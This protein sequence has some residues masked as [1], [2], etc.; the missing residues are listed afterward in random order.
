MAG[1]ITGGDAT[2]TATSEGCAVAE[3][4]GT[5]TV[6]GCTVVAAP[7]TERSAEV[8]EPL[9]AGTALP[10]ATSVTVGWMSRKAPVPAIATTATTAARIRARGDSIGARWSGEGTWLKNGGAW[11]TLE[12]CI[13]SAKATASCELSVTLSEPDAPNAAAAQCPV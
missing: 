8:V 9:L 11:P 1:A 12:D 13:S 3:L 5:D 7:V 4:A 6:D 10:A 2:A